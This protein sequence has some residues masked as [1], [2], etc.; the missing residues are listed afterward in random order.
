MSVLSR[1][2]MSALLDSQPAGSTVYLLGAGGCGM[3]ALGHLLLDRGFTIAGSDVEMNSAI[4]ELQNRGARIQIGHRAEHIADSVPF[5][6]II[7]SAIP[8][9]NVELTTAGALN[10]PTVRRGTV[11]ACL[12]GLREGICVAGMHGKTTTA[13]M[14][15][16]ALEQLTGDSSYAVG[17]QVSQLKPH[18]RFRGGADSGVGKG[19]SFFVAEVD[20]S[21]G[22]LREF[23]PDH[24]IVLNVD[25]EHLDY[26]ADF[27]A[28]CREFVEFSKRSRG[29][30]V[31][32]ADDIDL[33]RMNRELPNSVSFGFAS[34]ADY[35]AEL[36]ENTAHSTIESDRNLTRFRVFHRGTL[37]GVFVIRLSG[38]K[39]ITNATA[40]VA[41]LHQLQFAPEAIA[42]S[43]K[44]FVGADRRQQ[45][46]HRDGDFRVFEDYG[47]HPAEIRATLSAMRSLNPGRLLV[48][49]QPH[50]YTRTQFLRDQFAVSFLEADL[51]W[52]TE[53]YAASE[54]PIPG[55][56]GAALAEAIRVRGQSVEY[57]PSPEHLSESVRSAMRPGDLV[58]FLGAGDIT[59][60]AHAF[61]ERLKAENRDLNR[62]LY[63]ALAERLSHGSVVRR[64]EVLAKRTTLRVGG[65]ADCYVEP[66]SEYDLAIVLRFCFERRVPVTIIGR[67]SNLLIRDGGIRGVVVSLS[68]PEF[69]RIEVCESELRCGAGAKLKSIAA[70][71]K[72]HELG[73]F[74]FLEGI[75]GTVGGALRMNAGA[76]GSS[77][78][79]VVRSVRFMDREG[80]V[81]SRSVEELDVQ[82][83]C[84]SLF[85]DHIA[86]GAVMKGLPARREAI[87][88]RMRECSRKRWDSQPAASSAG[89][90]FKN[91]PAIPAGMLIE[92]LGLKGERVGGAVISDV[93]GNFI[94][95]DG[96]ASA[97]DVLELI[98]IVKR[99]AASVRG[100]QL[101]T[102][103][104]ILGE[105]LP[106][107][108]IE[109]DFEAENSKQFE[110]VAPHV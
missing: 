20:E 36:L 55:V 94:V 102:E 62:D 91:P 23:S 96:D 33:E 45:E 64:N 101:E 30:L 19:N 107:G 97:R 59:R 95:N 67:G 1:D 69:G 37:L 14:L 72:K 22:T 47:H 5:V 34:F 82:Y 99:K 6:L 27:D 57:T 35:R 109:K 65:R 11:L 8:Q 3:S 105:N 93:H 46:I 58:L 89:C 66:I 40:V 90:I 103:V 86:L 53:I 84:C 28:I 29:R 38:E 76:M 39:N 16:F 10:I 13:A 31:Y 49:F 100:I 4:R 52:L 70:A 21:D 7:S 56:S 12:I 110:R 54:P 77:V 18:G 74:E 81:Y 25:H 63:D 73:G 43:V 80:T 85:K 26:F 78:F 68:R 17:A 44:G 92:E 71:A 98:E 15:A 87:E 32:C 106:W 75:P 108:W 50:R 42:A 9:D 88:S 51:F 60:A 104:E 83:R 2:Q 79:T 61:A 24:S 48:V 41:M